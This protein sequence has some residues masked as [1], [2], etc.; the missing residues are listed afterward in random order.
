MESENV[1]H[2]R[3]RSDRHARDE[4]TLQQNLPPWNDPPERRRDGERGQEVADRM[5]MRCAGRTAR[6]SAERC[7]CH[8]ERPLS[9]STEPE[10]VDQ[11]ERHEQ[12]P[13]RGREARPRHGQ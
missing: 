3:V 13:G 11:R 8:K 9:P 6:D 10:Q 7:P 12:P 4:V 2:D 1:S 5:A